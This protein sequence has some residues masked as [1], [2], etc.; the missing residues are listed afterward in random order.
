MSELFYLRDLVVIFS[1]GIIIVTVA[2]R[3][4]LPAI[5]GFVVAGI[6]AGPKGLGLVND[7]HQV[8]I[9]AEIGVA[10]LL[11]GIGMELP[12]NR[13][14]RLWK[15]ILVA[16]AL[17]V[18][19]CL[20]A[21]YFVARQFD[22]TSG[23]ALFV[24]FVVAV[25]STAIVLRDLEQRGEIDAPHGRI[26][27]GILIF[28]DLCVVPMILTVPLLAG[29]GGVAQVPALTVVRSAAIIVITVL[30]ARLIIPRMMNLVARTRQRH[31]FIMTILLICAGTAWIL[32]HAGV[33][34]A[35]GAFLAGMI[36]AGS[37]YRHQALADIIPFRVVFTSLFFVS[38][39]M[40]LD[41]R[42]LLENMVTILLLFV[43]IVL[44]KF[45]VVFLTGSL[46][47][48]PIGVTAKAAMALAQVGE[49]A[50]V[51]VGIAVSYR[52]IDSPLASNLMAAAILS[53]LVTPILIALAPTIAAGAGKLGI[54]TRLLDV[55]TAKDAAKTERKMRGHVI[56]GGYGIAGIDLALALKD[57][58]IP[59]LIAELNP[60]NVRRARE[61]GEPAYFADITS[62]D[63][64]EYL[65]AGLA[66]EFVIVINDPA[67]I[68][69]A[70]KAACSI[71]PELHIT[72]RTRY[73]QDAPV[74]LAAGA[75]DVVAS[76][77]EAAA[78]VVE[79]V[80]GRFPAGAD[81]ID[82]HVARIRSREKTSGV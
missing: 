80:L 81:V 36:V 15:P 69:R 27:L 61:N 11:F 68:E 50:F 52:L 4:R 45:I 3:F 59:Y 31:V 37:Q 66:K 13:L 17:Q 42:Y 8:E 79:R 14:G 43:G 72:V 6:L 55:S 46:M 58:G 82:S 64:L 18:V 44:G 35:L 41:P 57:G 30:A 2:H 60:E 70:V 54:L 32:T 24:A 78:E 25:S 19:L 47:R 75:S 39:G 62:A 5:A 40:L 22:L 53:M 26:T 77:V 74:L 28:Q 67:A 9:L 20:A 71:A 63:V 48:L 12:L 34:L 56:I 51:L 1:L 16:G 76:E 49:F 10:L 73:L 65:G 29:E 7:I 23:E 38:I 33:S 21:A